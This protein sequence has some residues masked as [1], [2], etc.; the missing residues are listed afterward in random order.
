MSLEQSIDNLSSLIQQL[1]KQLEMGRH[2]NAAPAAAPEPPVTVR[3][4]KP[5]AEK[6]AAS[7][8]DTSASSPS[9]AQPASGE[10]PALDYLKDVAPR[11]SKLVVSNKL[12]A[13]EL[14]EQYKP[15]AKKL[16]EALEPHQ[17]A[18]CLAKINALLED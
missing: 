9:G 16:S 15:G 8:G 13:L 6:S 3:Q 17:F 12:A 4:G 1:I 7:S 10:S 5:Q 14:I 18:E 2:G 11:F